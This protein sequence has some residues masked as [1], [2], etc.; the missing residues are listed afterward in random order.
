MAGL[1]TRPSAN[2]FGPKRRDRSPVRDLIYNIGAYFVNLVRWNLAGLGQSSS[3]AWVQATFSSGDITVTSFGDSWGSQTAPTRNRV[4][5]GVYTITYPETVL[6]A[7]DVEV[8]PNFLGATVT[9]IVGANPLV[10]NYSIASGRI[11]TVR[12]FRA[13][14]EAATDGSFTLTLY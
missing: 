8:T 11:V 7:D 12:L 10:A 6:D 14:T 5:A 13:S 4:S 2:S 1:P 3:R 9:P